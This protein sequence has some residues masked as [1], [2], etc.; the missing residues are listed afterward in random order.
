MYEL[1]K[2]L[3]LLICHLLSILDFFDTMQS[4]P[5]HGWGL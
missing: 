2:G 3:I 4:I 1:G 5:T